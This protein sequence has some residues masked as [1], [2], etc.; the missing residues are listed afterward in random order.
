MAMDLLLWLAGFGV[1]VLSAVVSLIVR[2]W[3]ARGFSVDDAAIHG[4]E[5]PSGTMEA[6]HTAGVGSVRYAQDNGVGP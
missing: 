6:A 2:E 3:R 1:V 4:L 5:S